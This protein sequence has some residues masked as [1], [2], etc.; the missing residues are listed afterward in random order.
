MSWFIILFWF[1]AFFVLILCDSVFVQVLGP[2]HSYSSFTSSLPLALYLPCS[3]SC[4]LPDCWII[5]RSQYSTL[6]VFQWLLL[7][8][9]VPSCSFL[10]F[11]V[12]FWLCV[13]VPQDQPAPPVSLQCFNPLL[14][15]VSCQQTSKAI[16]TSPATPVTGTL[17]F[18]CEL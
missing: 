16:Y 7:D 18:S 13:P 9:L 8:F 6:P 3:F 5:P 11:L 17:L 14:L 10:W 12:L 15:C 1:R 4:K 2:S